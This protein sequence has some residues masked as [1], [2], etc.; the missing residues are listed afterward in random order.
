MHT[1]RADILES[2]VEMEKRVASHL[3]RLQG[4]ELSD[5]RSEDQ[6]G[7]V[8]VMEEFFTAQPLES[9]DSDEDEADG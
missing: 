2:S 6:L 3:N 8:E 5:F 9:D 1:F 4:L 7:I